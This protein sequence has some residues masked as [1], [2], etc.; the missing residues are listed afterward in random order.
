MA[1]GGRHLRAR[2]AAVAAVGIG[3]DADR[4]LLATSHQYLVGRRRHWCRGEN[5][6]GCRRIRRLECGSGW[7]ASTKST[8]ST[9][10]NSMLGEWIY[11]NE[12]KEI[13]PKAKACRAQEIQNNYSFIH[14]Q[15]LKLH[16][17]MIRLTDQWSSVVPWKLKAQSS[18]SM[19]RNACDCYVS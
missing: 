17:I 13:A 15:W 6:E 9:D 3:S 11:D 16:D 8:R 5:R 4:E 1:C 18:A 10:S 7:S 2:R 12:Q 14:C 19:F